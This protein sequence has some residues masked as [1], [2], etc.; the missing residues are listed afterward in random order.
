MTLAKDFTENHPNQIDVAMPACIR[1]ENFSI[2]NLSL[3]IPTN[4]NKVEENPNSFYF[5]EKQVGVMRLYVRSYSTDVSP[6]VFYENTRTNFNS[7]DQGK[8]L[9]ETN[10]S[11]AGSKVFQHNFISDETELAQNYTNIIVANGNV[12]EI[13]FAYSPNH[14]STYESLFG[15]IFNSIRISNNSSANNTITNNNIISVGDVAYINYK[16]TSDSGRISYSGDS[17]LT[18]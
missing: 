17:I 6:G 4:W 15:K 10:G 9:K 14:F 12:Y 5:D 1:F 16:K 7:N 3:N 18:I 8:I 13:I 2:G 11:I